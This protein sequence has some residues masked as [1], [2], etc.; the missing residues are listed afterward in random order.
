[1]AGSILSRLELQPTPVALLMPPTAASL[2]DSWLEPRSK[3][4]GE[5][6][7]LECFSDETESWRKCQVRNR[8]WALVNTVLNVRF[9]VSTAVTKMIIITVLNLRIP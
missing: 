7:K 3:W 9:E 2:E 1:M 5:H 8:V 6:D 4:L